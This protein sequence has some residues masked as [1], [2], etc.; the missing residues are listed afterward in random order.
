MS[1]KM[2]R[3]LVVY[4]MV[5]DLDSLEEEELLEIVSVFEKNGSPAN[6]VKQER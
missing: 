1:I 3:E 6:N 4:S 5:N 2:I